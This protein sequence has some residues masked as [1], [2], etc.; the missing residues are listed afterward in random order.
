VLQT[1]YFDRK[2]RYDELAT[3]EFFTSR[4]LHRGDYF[5]ATCH[6]RENIE[7]PSSLAAV[8]ELL[9]AVDRTVYF[10]AGYR[11]QRQLASFGLTLPPNVILVDPIGYTDMLTL[12]V[13]SR[14]VITDSGTVVEETAVLGV[15]S[16]QMR[17]STER[18][19][20]YDCRSS[21][22]FD[23]GAPGSVH[24][25]VDKLA[26]LHGTT[27]THGL[28]DG[29]ASERIVSDLVGRLRAGW[30]GGHD[31]A[32]SHLPVARSYQGDGLP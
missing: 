31:P 30:E 15:P 21:V 17:R 32:N 22:K 25:V 18:P 19:Q 5:L 16:V 10:P 13:N 20:V 2:D 7:S 6:R 28:G 4:G 23:P 8:L 24:D 27:W 1:Y 29:L 26:S 11:T 3:D 9:A 14:G 12:V